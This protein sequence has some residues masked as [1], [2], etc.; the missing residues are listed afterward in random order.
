M[1][2]EEEAYLT[3]GGGRVRRKVVRRADSTQRCDSRRVEG[4]NGDGNRCA[5]VS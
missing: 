2:G 4:E 1:V 3:G 5:E